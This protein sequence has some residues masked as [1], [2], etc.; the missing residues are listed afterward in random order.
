MRCGL[1]KTIPGIRKTILKKLPLAVA[2]MR[3]GRTPNT[4]ELSTFLPLTTERADLREQ[5]L[6][7]LLSNPLID[8][9]GLAIS[10]ASEG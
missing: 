5:W 3:E 4:L 8:G 2:A 6:R 10:T 9:G 7:R 1:E